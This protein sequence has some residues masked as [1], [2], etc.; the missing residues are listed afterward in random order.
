MVYM[1]LLLYT[2]LCSF[3]IVFL[4]QHV[5][6]CIGQ[7]C[8]LMLLPF[9]LCKETTHHTWLATQLKRSVKTQLHIMHRAKA[10]TATC[11]CTLRSSCYLLGYLNR[12]QRNTRPITGR[13]WCFWT[14]VSVSSWKMVNPLV[15]ALVGVLISSLMHNYSCAVSL[16]FF[17]VRT[18]LVAEN[19]CPIFYLHVGWSVHLKFACTRCIPDVIFTHVLYEEVT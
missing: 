1:Y 4:K 12:P 14:V 17:G 8:L 10:Q 16:Y 18:F 11:S 13:I 3:L 7:L 2:F 6:G 9:V 19:G 5:K 15:T